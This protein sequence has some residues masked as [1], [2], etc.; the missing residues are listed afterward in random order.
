MNE[1]IC[2]KCNKTTPCHESCLKANYYRL[3]QRYIR[4]FRGGS[5]TFFKEDGAEVTL[6]LLPAVAG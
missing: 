5:V 3:A 4:T 1:T 6:Q 2:E